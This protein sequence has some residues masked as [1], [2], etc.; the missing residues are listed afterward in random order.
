[1]VAAL[2]RQENSPDYVALES[3]L[4]PKEEPPALT[5]GQDPACH[6]VKSCDKSSHSCCFRTSRSRLL[7]N[8]SKVKPFSPGSEHLEDLTAQGLVA[9]CLVDKSPFFPSSPDSDPALLWRWQ[10]HAFLGLQ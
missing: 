6:Y 7:W 5:P 3:N 10:V 8:Q 1:M 4:R 9:N 2:K